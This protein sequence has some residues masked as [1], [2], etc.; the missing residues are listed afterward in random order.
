MRRKGCRNKAWVMDAPGYCGH[1]VYRAGYCLGCY[2]VIKWRIMHD[3]KE[4]KK[5]LE[6]L[7]TELTELFQWP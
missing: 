6:K 2:Q 3:I 5:I 4:Q 1:E 7:R